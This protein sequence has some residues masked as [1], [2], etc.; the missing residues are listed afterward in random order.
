[1]KCPHCQGNI[2]LLS[3]T[4][5]SFTESRECPHCNKPIALKLNAK[6]LLALTPIAFAFHFFIV[7]PAVIPLGYS[8][9]GV[10]WVSVLLALVLPFKLYSAEPM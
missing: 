5:N 10:V 3:K 7:R 4:L 8:G 1:M 2:G 9:N 6:L